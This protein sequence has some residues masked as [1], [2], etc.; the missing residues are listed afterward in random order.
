MTAAG[1][2]SLERLR[3]VMHAIRQGCPWDAEQTHTSLVRY[4]VEESAET[5]E[6]IESGDD[7]HLREE[8]GDLLLQVFFHAEI[9]A[10]S[11]RFTL[12]DV[13][14]GIADKLVARHPYVFSDAAT[15]DD[16]NA[17]WER[18]K[19]REKGRTSA[20]EGIPATLDTLARAE[21]VI[22]RARA[23]G[24]AVSLPDDPIDPD[25]AAAEL[26]EVVSRAQASGLDA[27]QLLRS[28]VRTLESDIRRAEESR[29]AALESA[30][31][32]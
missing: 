16:L 28:A 3:E 25:A 6:A 27:D 30:S 22:A 5:V 17:S 18:N 32:T 14:A 13:A 1:G 19:R 31:D 12:D 21:K 7:D 8:L 10:E 15:P 11:G 4:L 9:A 20:L 23:Q 24:I 2:G 29:Q 26:L